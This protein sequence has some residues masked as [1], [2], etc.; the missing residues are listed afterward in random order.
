MSDTTGLDVGAL[1]VVAESRV[2]VMAIQPATVLALLDRL[3]A[4]EAAVERVRAL[5]WSWEVAVEHDLVNDVPA[6]EA[7]ADVA[8]ALRSSLQPP[9]DASGGDLGWLQGAG[10]SVEEV[11]DS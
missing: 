11:A 4:A 10:G 3:E 9:S 8:A 2:K 1:R 7:L 5:G 6:I